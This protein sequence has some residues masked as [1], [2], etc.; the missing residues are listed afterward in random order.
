MFV[1][2]LNFDLLK[3]LKDLESG[4]DDFLTQITVFEDELKQDF[5]EHFKTST[6]PTQIIKILHT[7]LAQDNKTRLV[8]ILNDLIGISNVDQSVPK[9]IDE[10]WIA[11]EKVIRFLV[12][13]VDEQGRVKDLGEEAERLKTHIKTQQ[14]AMTDLE[15]KIKN[16]KAKI[17]HYI[18]G[19]ADTLNPAEFEFTKDVAELVVILRSGGTLPPPPTGGP[20]PPPP[21]LPGGGPPPPPPPPGMDAPPPPPPPGGGPPPPPGMGPPPPPGMGGMGIN[22]GPPL[23]KLPNYAPKANLRNFHIVSISKPKLQKS[24]FVQKG[25]A[26]GT[27]AIKLDT[28]EIEKMFGMAEKIAHEETD[29]PVQPQ[30]QVISLID[31]KR[32][33]NVGI[34][35]ASLRMPFLYIKDSIIAMDE[36]KVSHN[37]LGVIKA[38]A[39]TAEE[40]DTVKGYDG[41]LKFLAEP[42][43]F[44]LE[45]RSIPSL[46]DRLD[47]WAFKLRFDGEVS[48][49][50]PDIESLRLGAREMQ[51][52]E[53]LFKF[54]TI[55]LAM[56]NYLNAK[57]RYKNSYG[58]KLD[59]LLKL[60]D[61]KTSDG[62]SNLLCY[63]IEYVE[64]QYPDLDRFYDD[65][66][67]VV[68]AKRVALSS[69]KETMTSL[70]KS[71]N[72]LQKTI[73]FN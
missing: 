43:K 51:K 28:A 38:I 62:K 12:G 54:L 37:Q 70:S 25:I 48:S 20:P 22:T 56:S 27:T 49:L 32:A 58:F 60:R 13:N 45:M 8:Q 42:D 61:T 18:C 68:L 2:F 44:F 17:V 6:D 23:P 31:G 57:S 4:N 63:L 9:I 69:V 73:Y 66:P 64:R 47:C 52:S 1:E 3:R 39:P 7:Q 30:Q 15:D 26:E 36:A 33:Y 34:Q 16:E 50:R 5:N 65:L 72:H 35:L 11:T 24:I 10:N 29:E 40:I 14:F 46:R 21:P 67:N 59:T 19:G 55:V 71:L 53:K 41:D